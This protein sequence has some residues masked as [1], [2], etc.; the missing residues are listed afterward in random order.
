M[1]KRIVVAVVS[2]WL[3]VSCAEDEVVPRTNPR[4]SVAFVQTVDPSGVEFAASVFDYGSDEILEHGFVFAKDGPLSVDRS[5]IVRAA[6]VPA[7]EFRLKANYGMKAGDQMIVSA[8][9]K[10]D[11]GVVYSLPYSFVSQGSDG[12]VIERYEIP[13]QVYFGDTI[14]V[15]AKSLPRSLGQYS[16]E[17]QGKPAVVAELGEGYFGF[18]IPEGLSFEEN[19]A[20]LEVFGTDLKIAGKVLHLDLP[21]KFRDAEFTVGAAQELNYSQDLVITGKYLGKD[22]PV[23][24]YVSQNG[25]KTAL[26][27]SSATEERV[28]V[29]LTA[30]FGEMK[31][32]LDV[33]VRG[34]HYQL[35]G[36]LQLRETKIFPGQATTFH[37]SSG[38]FVLKGE[39]FNP[40]SVD[41]NRLEFSPDFLRYWVHSVSSSEIEISYEYRGEQ[42]GARSTDLFVVNGG[43]RSA[44]SL[45]LRWTAPAI[46]IM[47]FETAD[48]YLEGRAVS[49]ENK[50]YL[51]SN[52]GIFEIDPFAKSHSKLADFPLGNEGVSHR[53]AIAAE[54]KVYFSLSVGYDYS[55]E[56]LFYVFDPA[57]RRVTQLPSIPSR[58]NSFHSIVYHQGYL[59][60]HG[61]RIEPET[62]Y[63]GDIQRYRFDLARNTWEQL[64]SLSEHDG[65]RNYHNTF[66]WKGEIYS[67]SPI[68]LD[69]ATR[70]GTG[71]FKFD[72]SA[73]TWERVYFLEGQTLSSDANQAIVIGDKM[74]LKGPYDFWEMELGTWKV[75]NPDYLNERYAFVYPTM[76]FSVG[77]K[78]Y[79]V[80]WYRV[81]EFDAEYFY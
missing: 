41:Y 35:E 14:R 50:G 34:K 18:V 59:Y 8:F 39:N 73:Y 22:L 23:V 67:V 65:Y 40:H 13:S 46:P 24:S 17:V 69:D 32:K 25:D 61:D 1:I 51:V 72:T 68:A 48:A 9:I 19:G 47:L 63:D 77:G 38:V 74:Y 81:L 79:F 12:F 28:T 16:V 45:N 57:T 7:A 64:P 49:L 62:G 76:G 3:L 11:S 4:F 78:F 42:A 71:V 15:Y 56:K 29:K 33:K 55:A 30:Y 27:V 36:R 60:Y 5:E 58:D 70:Y 66:E 43:V 52:R 10:T 6:G 2:A 21:L 26:Q 53:F 54:G 80:D 20:L 31:P 44:N 37:G 75:G